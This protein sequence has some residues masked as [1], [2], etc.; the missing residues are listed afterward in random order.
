M[1]AMTGM[2]SRF[3]LYAN[4]FCA[5]LPSEVAALSTQVA[6][7]TWDVTTGNDLGTPCCKFE[8][9]QD[10]CVLPFPILSYWCLGHR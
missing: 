2:T 4:Q 7:G 9:G 1:A 8:P 6:S 3:Y 10:L 5:D